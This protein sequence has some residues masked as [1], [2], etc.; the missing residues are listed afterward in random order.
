MQEGITSLGGSGGAAFPQ[1][2]WGLVSRIGNP[3]AAAYREGMTELCRRYWKPV[4]FYVRLAWAKSNEDAKDLTQAFFLWL[5]EGGAITTYRQERGGFRGYL[6]VLL[7]R[8]LSHQDK[9]L[10]AL[11]RGGAAHIV[12]IDPATAPAGDGEADPQRAFDREW[13]RAVI[14]HAVERVRDR[15]ERQGRTVQFRVFQEY[16]MSSGDAK[17]SYAEL[18]ARLALKEGDVRYDLSV[19]RQEV[20]AEIR[21]E[22]ARVTTD[23][24]ELEAEWRELLGP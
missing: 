24:D 19:V 3:A 16:V 13:I 18:A 17:P 9:A 20:R 5:V 2:T 21:A 8:F 11:K 10:K 23:A 1:T 22:L 7:S 14:D 4:Y 6:K 12:A 15:L